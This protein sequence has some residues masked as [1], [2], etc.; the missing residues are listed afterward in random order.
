MGVPAATEESGEAAVGVAAP[1]GAVAAVR[2]LFA[3]RDYRYYWASSAVFAIGIWAYLTAMGW[4]ATELTDS[5]FAVSMVNVIYFVPMFLFALPAG[6]LADVWDRRWNA[7]LSR[8]LSAVAIAV[9][10]ALAFADALTYPLL[11]GFSFLVGLSVITELA[12]RQAFVAQLVEPRQLVNAT[13]LTSVQGGLARVLGPFAAGWLIVRFGDGG[14][15]MVFVVANL[16]FVAAFWQIDTS[17]T[18]MDGKRSHPL[19]ELRDAFRY[20]RGRRDALAVVLL[21][22]LAG[23]VG[24]IYLAL[25]PLMARDV[26]GGDAVTLGALTTAVG[27]GSVPGALSLSLVPEDFSSE[28]RILLAAMVLWGGGIVGFSLSRVFVLSL[29]LLAVSGLGFGLQAILVRTILLRIVESNY[30]GRVLGTLMLTWG[31][32][33][34][35]TLAGGSLAELV[36]VA[37]V[38]GLSGGAILAITAGLVAFNPRLARL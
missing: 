2:A 8:G 20:L 9:M 7:I 13:A 16:L 33:I 6:V 34:V 19:G 37:P 31:A 27:V 29:V 36:G 17:G 38:V 15:Y 24:W 10:A 23:V 22:V 11:A 1:R 5:A 18:V 28:G 12:A 25:M 35:G 3:D 26:L 32:N 4:T 21:S 14:G 30:H